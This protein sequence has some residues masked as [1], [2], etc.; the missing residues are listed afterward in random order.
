[1]KSESKSSSEVIQE[2]NNNLNNK[3]KN[4]NKLQNKFKAK[5]ILIVGSI[6]IAL[7][8][9]FNVATEMDKTNDNKKS[10]VIEENY[11]DRSL[12]EKS[13]YNSYSNEPVERTHDKKVS[14]GFI[15]ANDVFLRPHPSTNNKPVALLQKGA[16]IDVIDMSDSD[17]KSKKSSYM[18]KYD[19]IQA[20]DID[21]KQTI[22]LNKGLALESLSF[23]KGPERAIATIN[24]KQGKRR[25]LLI[26]YSKDGVFDI[27][28]KISSEDWFKVKTTN[29][30]TGWV[31]GKFI[32]VN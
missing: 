32:D 30:T 12:K 17:N 4:T 6:F 18:L 8:V 19:D 5:N 23:G 24:T 11:T 29:G 31:Y 15:N 26:H 25:V 7:A 27:L 14:I 20:T 2:I 9:V 1:M 16:K 22:I 13:S 3:I 21:T 28:E 10:K